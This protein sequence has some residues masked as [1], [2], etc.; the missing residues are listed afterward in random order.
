[1]TAQTILSQIGNKSL[2]MIGAKGI[3]AVENGVGFQVAKVAAGFSNRVTIT[4]NS[5]DLYDIEFFTIRKHQKKVNKV[6][7]DV[8]FDGLNQCIEQGTGHYTSL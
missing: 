5:L 7:N 3:H 1:M 6:F 2:Y 4:L 8:Y